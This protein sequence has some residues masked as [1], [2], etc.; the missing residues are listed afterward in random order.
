M[1]NCTHEE[2]YGTSPHSYVESFT[3]EG[4]LGANQRESPSMRATVTAPS[5]MNTRTVAYSTSIVSSCPA[6]GRKMATKTPPGAFYFRRAEEN[7]FMPR[8]CELYTIDNT[9]LG[10]TSKSTKKIPPI[11]IRRPCPQFFLL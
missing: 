10:N 4:A 7:G 5:T 1:L 3:A 11:C 2:P 8:G 6:L 9:I